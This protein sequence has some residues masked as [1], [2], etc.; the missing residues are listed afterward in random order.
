MGPQE[1]FAKTERKVK[2]CSISASFPLTILL[3]LLRPAQEV[4]HPQKLESGKEQQQQKSKGYGK[5]QDNSLLT[6]YT[7]LY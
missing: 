5:I 6:C 4:S 7:E 2:S 3:V 1:L